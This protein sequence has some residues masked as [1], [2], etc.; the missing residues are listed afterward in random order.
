MLGKLVE[1]VNEAT[2][3]KFRIESEGQIS[4]EEF[5]LVLYLWETEV[6][7]V[8]THQE[9]YYD[10][11]LADSSQFIMDVE[12]LEDFAAIM[13]NIDKLRYNYVCGFYEPEN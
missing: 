13:R 11:N 3:G 5:E 7:V 6:P 8:V 10:S 1:L 4:T 12:F 9:V 2:W